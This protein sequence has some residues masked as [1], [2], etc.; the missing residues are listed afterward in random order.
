[1]CVYLIFK[2]INMNIWCCEQLDTIGT[3]L[4]CLPTSGTAFAWDD[5]TGTELDPQEVRR[6]RE[7][8]MEFIRNMKV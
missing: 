6:A 7:D 8:E 3:A 4:A 5:V 2:V 1:M